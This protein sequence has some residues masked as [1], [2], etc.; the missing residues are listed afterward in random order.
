MENLKLYDK[1]DDIY[2][3]YLAELKNMLYSDKNISDES[4][5]I[6]RNIIKDKIKNSLIESES[7]SSEEPESEEKKK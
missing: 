5:N 3:M 7:S 4:K 1:N 6:I 2:I